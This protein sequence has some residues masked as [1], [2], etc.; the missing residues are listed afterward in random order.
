MASSSIVEEASPARFFTNPRFERTR[1]FLGE[2]LPEQN[3]G[4]VDGN[5]STGSQLEH[6]RHGRGSD[7]QKASYRGTFLERRTTLAADT[8]LLVGQAGTENIARCRSD[9]VIRP[10]GH[11]WSLPGSGAGHGGDRHDQR[12]DPIDC[13]L[14]YPTE[15]FK[16]PLIYNPYFEKHD[17]DAVVVPMGCKTEDYPHF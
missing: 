12:H 16:A 13:H 6:R 2:I 14:G 10:F 3:C 7:R 9:Q 4:Q 1:K 11:D 5:A 15:T 17:I 8:R